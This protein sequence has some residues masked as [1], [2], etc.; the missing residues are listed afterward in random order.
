MSHF[1]PPKSSKSHA[2][3][4]ICSDALGARPHDMELPSLLLP[5]HKGLGIDPGRAPP[6][7]IDVVPAVGSATGTVCTSKYTPLTESVLLRPTVFSGEYLPLPQRVR[8][9]QDVISTHLLLDTKG[10]CL[11]SNNVLE[12]LVFVDENTTHNP[13][14]NPVDECM[15]FLVDVFHLNPERMDSCMFYILKKNGHVKGMLEWRTAGDN[16]INTG[17]FLT[18][19]VERRLC[20]PA[21]VEGVEHGCSF[22]VEVVAIATNV[23]VRYACEVVDRI[24]S[25]FVVQHVSCSLI[26]SFFDPVKYTKGDNPWQILDDRCVLVDKHMCKKA[27]V[28]SST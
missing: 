10:T 2:V 4:E 14:R 28:E 6:E 22:R 24:L 18:A 13:P 12:M 23:S 26:D 9:V 1:R 20:F 5:G 15:R 16:H 19:G 27:R 21:S 7:C 3:F 25:M 17:Q 11:L 8:R